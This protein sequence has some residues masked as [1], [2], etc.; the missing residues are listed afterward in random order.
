MA[1]IISSEWEASHKSMFVDTNK[2]LGVNDGVLKGETPSYD[3]KI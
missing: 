2:P 3:E 1:I